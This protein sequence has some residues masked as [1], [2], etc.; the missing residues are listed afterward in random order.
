MMQQVNLYVEELRPKP[1]TLPAGM[2]LIIWM[3][4]FLVLLAL[5]AWMSIQSGSAAAEL[6]AARETRDQLVNRVEQVQ[7]TLAARKVSPDLVARQKQL[8]SE[9]TRARAFN[10]QVAQRLTRETGVQPAAIMTGLARRVDTSW[11]WLTGIGMD[12]S[13]AFVLKGETLAPKRLPE[14]LARLSEEPAFR[15][16]TFSYLDVEREEGASASRFVISS[17]AQQEET[18]Q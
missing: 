5:G 10:A 18:R 15:G 16:A 6:A 4:G 9:L 8:K 12:L 2:I 3:A 1:V 7:A 14:W 17:V 11:L 13:G